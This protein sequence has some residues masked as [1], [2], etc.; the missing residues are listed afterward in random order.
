M[1]PYMVGIFWRVVLFPV[2][3]SKASWTACGFHVTLEPG[4]KDFPYAVARP[5]HSSVTNIPG[6]L[7]K[8]K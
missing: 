8:L 6:P 4:L 5:S 7:R 1:I 3:Y 2:S